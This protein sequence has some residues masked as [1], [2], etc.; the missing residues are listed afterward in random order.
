MYFYDHVVTSTSM[1]TRLRDIADFSPCSAVIL[2]SCKLDAT[3]RSMHIFRYFSK[4]VL[5]NRL[6]SIRSC[7][8][9]QLW[10]SLAC[11]LSALLLL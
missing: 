4:D 7:P 1:Q 11:H 10:S 6:L 3:E 9:L 2:M 5:N 8:L